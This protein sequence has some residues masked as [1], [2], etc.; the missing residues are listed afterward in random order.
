MARRHREPRLTFAELAAQPTFSQT[1]AGRSTATPRPGSF[2]LAG[3]FF[4]PDGTMLGLVDDDLSPEAAQQALDAGGLVLVDECGCGG[5]P[6]GCPPQ[7]LTDEELATL[8]GSE[9][10]V[11]TRRRRG[12]PTWIELFSHAGRS[13]VFVHGEVTWGAVLT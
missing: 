11:L 13:V 8:R 12:A 3:E 4:H 2:N 7:W 9:P 1:P 10:P 5:R 6:D